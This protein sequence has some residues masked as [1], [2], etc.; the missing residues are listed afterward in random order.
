VTGVITA[1]STRA[2]ALER[3]RVATRAA[4]ERARNAA[5]GGHAH[6]RP[7]VDF[8]VRHAV[9][10]QR[11]HLPAVTH[12]FQLGR[13]AQVLQE[14][15]HLRRG[16]E[17]LQGIGEVVDGVLGLVGVAGA[18]LHVCPNVLMRYYINLP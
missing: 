4:L 10:D 8:A 16:S 9:G 11:H 1:P 5:D 2:T 17:P 6:Q 3:C 12:C 18:A 7:L 14:R 13:S 15:A